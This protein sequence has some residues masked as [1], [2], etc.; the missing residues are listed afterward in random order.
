MV[1]QPPLPARRQIVWVAHPCS[2]LPQSRR[3]PPPPA[4]EE[5]PDLL[6]LTAA[7]PHSLLSFSAF[8]LSPPATR[9]PQCWGGRKAGRRRLCRCVRSLA[10]RAPPS[11]QHTGQGRS[12]PG[13]PAAGFAVSLPLPLR[14]C[15]PPPAFRDRRVLVLDAEDPGEAGPS[16]GGGG[17]TPGQAWG[18]TLGQAWGTTPG[19]A[20]GT[21]P[22]Q[23]WGTTP[24]PA[25]PGPPHIYQGPL[26]G[27]GLTIPPF[28]AHWNGGDEAGGRG[29]RKGGALRCRVAAGEALCLA[30][31]AGPF[32][33]FQALVASP[34]P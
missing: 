16:G 29:A 3:H 23:A 12:P 32:R 11:R 27:G 15:P 14:P 4:G 24:A 22:G 28:A 26:V 8:G 6:P 33:P 34:C 10:G 1:R 7:S 5:K 17:A 31:A 13:W 18:T 9:P 20:S 30:G 2:C 19:Q 25:Q 21:T